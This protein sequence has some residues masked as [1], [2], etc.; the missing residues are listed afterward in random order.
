MMKSSPHHAE[1][2]AVLARR[3]EALLSADAA[4]LDQLLH[5]GFRYVDSLGRSLDR[6]QYLTSR[7]GGEI[8][9]THH[10]IS[11]VQLVMLG[12]GHALVMC[13]VHDAGTYRGQPFESRSR[14]IHVCVTVA[15]RWL[16]LFGQS[17]AV[18]D[19][20]GA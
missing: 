13:L 1:V 12:D 5:P 3:R 19:S 18:G 4:E 16:F 17:T 11:D 7:R 2:L 14:C 6:A 9:F 8:T 20:P 15:G 10:D